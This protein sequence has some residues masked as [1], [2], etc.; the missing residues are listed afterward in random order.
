MT[1]R[2]KA[3]GEAPTPD[4]ADA[5]TLAVDEVK[6]V[7]ESVDGV[8]EGDPAYASYLAKVK[9]DAEAK[10]A[11]IGRRR[12]QA[13]VAAHQAQLTE[14]QAAVSGALKALAGKPK[15]PPLARLK[16]RSGTW[17]G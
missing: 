5:A 11:E 17:K 4:A 14:A 15:R 1:E 2:M 9:K 3:L 7:A 10:R 8:A 12:T 16:R 6:G 13:T